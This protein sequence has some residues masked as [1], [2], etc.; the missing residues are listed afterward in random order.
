[1]GLGEATIS[2]AL[3]ADRQIN[4][5]TFTVKDGGFVLDKNIVLNSYFSLDGQNAYLKIN[6]D[7]GVKNNVIYIYSGDLIMFDENCIS[8]ATAINF[9]NTETSTEAFSK[10][11]TMST[12]TISNDT[13][14]GNIN[15]AGNIEFVSDATTT[16]KLNKFN[17][18][19]VTDKFINNIASNK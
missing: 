1:M 19:K 17:F 9:Y 4:I 12:T 16:A 5:S 6:E 10:F 18:Y 11:H 13:I 8:S 15:I 2:G 7:A 14:A 3:D